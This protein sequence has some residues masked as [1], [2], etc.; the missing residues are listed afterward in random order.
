MPACFTQLETTVFCW[1]TFLKQVHLMKLCSAGDLIC[2]K[3]SWSSELRSHNLSWS[4]S[5]KYSTFLV[6]PFV[7]NTPSQ[8]S[9]ITRKDG[10]W[11]GEWLKAPFWL[12]MLILWHLLCEGDKGKTI[13][14]TLITQKLSLERDTTHN[15]T[16][17]MQSIIRR[18]GNCF[19][20]G[21]RPW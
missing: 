10:G 21:L 13:L 17:K 19:S 4:G 6:F 15:F 7:L 3:P 9:T 12:V 18:K 11:F 20:V 8:R 2:L 5:N 14:E 16:I 1:V